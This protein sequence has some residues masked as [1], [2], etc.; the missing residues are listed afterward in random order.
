MPRSPIN[1][2]VLMFGGA[3]LFE[4]SVP[5][6]VFGMDRSDSGA[7]KFSLRTIAADGDP[8]IS[9][10]GVR[11]HAR[12]GL[13]DLDDAGIIVIPTWRAVDEPLPEA[14]AEAIRV[15]HGDGAI[16]VGLCLGTF[17]LAAAGLLDGRRAV[18]HSRYAAE[19]AARYPKVRVDPAVL[20]VDDG[21]IVTSGGGTAG[22][23]ACIHVVAR[24][25]GVKAAT[26]IADRMAIP[27]QRSGEQTQAVPDALRYGSDGARISEIMEYVVSNLDQKF[28]IDYLAREFDLS[29]RTL[30]RHFRAATGLSPIQW[31]LHQRLLRTQKLLEE[32]DLTVDAIAHQV[33]LSTAVSLRPIFRRAT[34]VS[35]QAYRA[36]FRDGP[37]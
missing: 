7:P 5:I 26:A 33:G 12:Y 17:V 6:S 21:D 13:H 31:L 25:W 9:T 14:T 24:F 19:L 29:R 28:D 11:I 3:S 35:P 22:L 32:T 34:G 30:D 36:G 37:S 18:T 16:V 27:P 2:A 15:A 10:G 20:Y 8:M 1:V 23:D 4:M